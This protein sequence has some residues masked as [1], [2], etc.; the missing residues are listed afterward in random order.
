M[1]HEKKFFLIALLQMTMFQE[2]FA[3]VDSF[4]ESLHFSQVDGF[5]FSGVVV[6][7]LRNF[8]AFIVKPGQEFCHLVVFFSQWDYHNQYNLKQRI[9]EIKFQLF[10]WIGSLF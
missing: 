1:V 6:A 3:V 5:L 2:Y 7:C 10:F 8:K 9:V 4:S